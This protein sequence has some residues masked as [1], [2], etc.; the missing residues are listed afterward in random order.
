MKK[1]IFI[2]GLIAAIM[3]FWS[4]EDDLIDPNIQDNKQVDLTVQKGQESFQKNE[5]IIHKSKLQNRVFTSESLINN[6]IGNT[7][8]RK[9]Q[10]Y[11]PPGYEKHGDKV[12]PVI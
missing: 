11:T 7:P 9:L 5:L 4:C 1:I 12:Y 3:I 8:I 2:I 10:I 6:V